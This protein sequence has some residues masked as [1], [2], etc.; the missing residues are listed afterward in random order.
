MKFNKNEF[1]WKEKVSVN[2]DELVTK[3]DIPH[4]N[5]TLMFE[6]SGE[7]FKPFANNSYFNM[8]VLNIDETKLYVGELNPDINS[9]EEYKYK[10]VYNKESDALIDE[11]SHVFIYNHK[12]YDGTNFV[13]DTN[14]AVI[15]LG[16]TPMDIGFAEEG[17]FKLY[18]VDKLELDNN[19]LSNNVIIA[20]SLTVGE[21]IGDIGIYSVAEGAE[22]MASG[23]LSH[24]EGASTTASGSAS[25]AEGAGTTA[26]GGMSHAEGD[27][28]I[29]SNYAS[30]AE[31][32][33]TTASGLYSH[34]EGFNTTASG[35]YSHT[36][37]RFTEASGTGS[38]T[39]GDSTKASSDYQHVQGKYNI[40]DTENKYAHIVGNGTS[41]GARSNA[42]T[43]DWQ[44]NGWYSGKLSQEGTPTEDKDLTTKKYVDDSIANQPTFSFNDSGELVVTINGVTKTFVPK[45]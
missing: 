26:S 1:G 29:S 19:C 21:R 42:H 44:G 24:S 39:E 12:S 43:L 17:Y 20:N 33:I 28:S 16:I 36:E 9:D 6:I 41:D 34:A 32:G 11:N 25:H 45:E 40:E 13:E 3:N 30:H 22:T 18:E 14:S 38:H 15:T 31:G 10:F 5:E 2:T 23:V 8:D 4:Y 27:S 35:D 37:G 7:D